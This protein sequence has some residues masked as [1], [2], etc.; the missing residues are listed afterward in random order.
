M[1]KPNPTGLKGSSSRNVALNEFI[2]DKRAIVVLEYSS[3]I[4]QLADN[5][6]GQILLEWGM[7]Y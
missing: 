5:L 4:T 2:I 1:K 6:L 3:D 7:D